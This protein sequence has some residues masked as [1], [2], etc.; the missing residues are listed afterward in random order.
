MK[1]TNGLKISFASFVNLNQRMAFC[2]ILLLWF[3]NV[4]YNGFSKNSL[5][6]YF[7]VL[8]YEST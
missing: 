1:K 4:K 3:T 2:I 5:H 6:I 7:M 8:N